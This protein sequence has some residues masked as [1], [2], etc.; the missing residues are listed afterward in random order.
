[1]MCGSQ[2][3]SSNTRADLISRAGPQRSNPVVVITRRGEGRGARPCATDEQLVGVGHGRALPS[4]KEGIRGGARC[5]HS[6]AEGGVGRRRRKR[7]ARGGPRLKVGGR[8]TGG[9]HGEHVLH[10][11]HARDLGRVEAQRLV[12]R[13]R[14]LPSRK[15]GMR[16]GARDAARRGRRA[17]GDDGASG[18]HTGEVL[19][20]EGWGPGHVR[21]A[22]RTCNSCL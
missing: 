8:G 6:E 9:A 3:R 13:R 17:W 11:V 22:L 10:A 14:F 21:S 16:C 5:A 7:H 15:E 20:T 2:S 4:R 19:T 18:M 1:M 12:E